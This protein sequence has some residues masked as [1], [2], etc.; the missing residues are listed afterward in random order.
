[1]S[2]LGRQVISDIA[3][4]LLQRRRV[5]GHPYEFLDYW[6]RGKL[7]SSSTS[8]QREKK[9]EADLIDNSTPYK[10]SCPGLELEST[11]RSEEDV[12]QLAYAARKAVDHLIERLTGAGS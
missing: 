8:V 4:M 10:R 7:S 11:T 6:I 1:M 12:L 5:A 9:R 2:T 3:W